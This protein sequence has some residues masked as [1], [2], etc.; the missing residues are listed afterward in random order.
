MPERKE[1]LVLKYLCNV[2]AGK[3]TYLISPHDIAKEIC[4]KMVLSIN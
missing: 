2:C 3:K 1:R 4:N